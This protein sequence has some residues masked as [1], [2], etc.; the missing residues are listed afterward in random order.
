LLTRRLQAYPKKSTSTHFVKKKTQK[1]CD[2]WNARYN[3]FFFLLD[4]KKIS[5]CRFEGLYILE[6]L[7]WHCHSQH[8]DKGEI[9]WDAE[10]TLCDIISLALKGKKRVVEW[11]RSERSFINGPSSCEKRVREMREINNFIYIIFNDPSWL[12]PWE[13]KKNSFLSRVIGMLTWLLF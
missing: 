8:I 2:E 3:F 9:Q 6:G 1:L 12:S 11:V 5:Y 7:K 10:W 4:A 13:R